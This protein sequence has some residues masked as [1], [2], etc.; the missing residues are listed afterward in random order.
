MDENSYKEPCNY[1]PFRFLRVLEAATSAAMKTPSYVTTRLKQIPF[2]HGSHGCPGRFLI[3]SELKI[4]I[5][6]VTNYNIKSQSTL[7]G[8]GLKYKRQLS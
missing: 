3:D 4:I 1:D 7:G 2:G 6:Y 8:S 5:T